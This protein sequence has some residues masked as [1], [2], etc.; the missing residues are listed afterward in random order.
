MLPLGIDFK[1][2]NDPKNIPYEDESFD[3]IINRHGDF[4]AKEIYRLLKKG[5]IFITQQV[6]E[7]NDRDLVKIVLP[8]VEKPFPHMNLAEQKR[9]F[10]AAGF[11][12]L[13]EGE[14]FGPIKFYDIA[15]FVWFARIIEWEFP[16]FSV[17]NCFEHLLTMQKIIEEKGEVEGTTHRYMIAAQKKY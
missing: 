10:E 15:A 16:N 1:E 11:Q 6:G 7:D 17:E 12:I 13:E 5:G 4:N 8:D 14:V 9:E 2:C 3:M